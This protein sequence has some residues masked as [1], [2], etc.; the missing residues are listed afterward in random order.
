MTTEF[1][2]LFYYGSVETICSKH[3]SAAAALCAA[4]ACEKRGGADHRIVE[5]TEA[6]PYGTS[7]RKGQYVVT[8]KHLEGG[9][10]G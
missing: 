4:A 3:R 1:W 6:I 9:G 2:T 10:R 8:R 7:Q 5:V